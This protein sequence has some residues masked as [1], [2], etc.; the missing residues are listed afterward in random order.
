MNWGFWRHMRLS[1]SGTWTRSSTCHT[2]LPSTTAGVWLADTHL[3]L[4]VLQDLSQQEG[5]ATLRCVQERLDP[6]VAEAVAH[7]EGDEWPVSWVLRDALTGAATGRR[8]HLRWWKVG[9]CGSSLPAGWTV[10]PAGRPCRGKLQW[11]LLGPGPADWLPWWTCSGGWG[12]GFKRY[13]SFPTPI[14]SHGLLTHS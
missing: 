3:Q 2:S 10:G 11:P 14:I 12:G 7:C 1:S 9:G 6:V 13:W 5:V 8:G 4:E